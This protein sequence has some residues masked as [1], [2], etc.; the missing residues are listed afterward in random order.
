MGVGIEA[1]SHPYQNCMW[2][3]PVALLM[4]GED[5]ALDQ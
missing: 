2:L 3:I 1:G 5:K 4:A